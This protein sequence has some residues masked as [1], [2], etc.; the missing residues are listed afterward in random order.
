MYS[1][2]GRPIRVTNTIFRNN[3]SRETMYGGMDGGNS[4]ALNLV[5]SRGTLIDNCLFTGNRGYGAGAVV[6]A[7]GEVEITNSRFFNN[8]SFYNGGAISGSY[9]Y[10]SSDES[11]PNILTMK[12]CL[13][14][15]LDEHRVVNERAAEQRVGE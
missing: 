3:T 13:M 10:Y 2:Q 11:Q 1:L 14:L 4:G 12:N 15:R 5:S 9:S 6:M 7:G 8:H